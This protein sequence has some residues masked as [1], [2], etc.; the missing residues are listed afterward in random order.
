MPALEFVA[1]NFIKSMLQFT[2]KDIQVALYI[3][4]VCSANALQKRIG[5]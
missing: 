1:V 3:W 4:V 2:T 5:G